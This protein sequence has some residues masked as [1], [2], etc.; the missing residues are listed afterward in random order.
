MGCSSVQVRKTM[1]KWEEYIRS[2]APEL[3]RQIVE[4]PWCGDLP[5]LCV[6]EPTLV[7]TQEDERNQYTTLGI[8]QNCLNQSLSL[9]DCCDP[10]LTTVCYCSLISIERIRATQNWLFLH[11]LEMT[12]DFPSSFQ[13][14]GKLCSD[15]RYIFLLCH[16]RET[17]SILGK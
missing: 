14:T 9:Q 2:Q 7:E 4:Q 3:P 8:Q 1:S 10:E 13:Q 5:P 16:G 11:K 12:I 15:D 17:R 6:N